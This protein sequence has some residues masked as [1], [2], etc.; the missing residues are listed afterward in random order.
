MHMDCIKTC[1]P[2]GFHNVI[3][4]MPFLAAIN[5]FMIAI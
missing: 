4:N 2:R 3:N 5:Y 1:H